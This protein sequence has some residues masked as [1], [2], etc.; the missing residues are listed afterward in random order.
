MI[1]PQIRRVLACVVASGVLASA[2]DLPRLVKR[3]ESCRSLGEDEKTSLLD[4][5]YLQHCD[6][7]FVAT[8]TQ[9]RLSA[10]HLSPEL[11]SRLREPFEREAA[12]L[13]TNSLLAI[14]AGDP[15]VEKVSGRYESASTATTKYYQT[16]LGKGASWAIV[17]TLEHEL[18]YYEDMNRIVRTLPTAMKLEAL[19]DLLAPFPAEHHLFMRMAHLPWWQLADP[20]GGRRFIFGRPD[21]E[22]GMTYFLDLLDADRPLITAL[23][24]MSR[25]NCFSTYIDYTSEG[26]LRPS[27]IVTAAC[28]RGSHQIVTEYKFEEFSYKVNPEN[29][30]I[31]AQSLELLQDD[32]TRTMSGA[33]KFTAWPPDVLKH[34]Y[35]GE[36]ERK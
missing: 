7:R 22:R 27:R 32:L 20:H 10:S 24:M 30:M 19:P 26:P 34:V 17:R 6:H 8:K 25:G 21:H 31:R 3:L 28:V 33:E 15:D 1:G 4:G 5:L 11:D 16:S 23:A 35:R 18:N 13:A 2:Q 9:W 14:V 29:L 12:R 36:G